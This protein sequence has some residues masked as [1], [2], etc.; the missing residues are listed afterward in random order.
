MKRTFALALAAAAVLGTA[1]VASAD[2]LC[3]TSSGKPIACAPHPEEFVPA[4]QQICVTVGGR[5]VACV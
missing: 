4:H 1:G 5:P 2:H 3:V